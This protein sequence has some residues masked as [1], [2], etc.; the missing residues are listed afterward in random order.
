MLHLAPELRAEKPLAVEPQLPASSKGLGLRAQSSCGSTLW[1]CSG[2]K[3]REA[4]QAGPGLR[5]DWACEAAACPGCLLWAPT[6][7]RQRLW[8][9]RASGHC[10]GQTGTKGTL[11]ICLSAWYP[12]QACEPGQDP[13]PE[14][15]ESGNI[16]CPGDLGV[17]AVPTLN[18]WDHQRERSGRFS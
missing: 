11:Q 6:Q 13:G 15:G 17:G 3:G 7:C 1:P 9:A 10:P 4:D 12:Q 2:A 16:S 14:P 8:L 5:A 18:P